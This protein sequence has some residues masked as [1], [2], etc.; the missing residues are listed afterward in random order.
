MNIAVI[1]TGG[2]QYL[3]K[4]GDILKVEKID[5]S[6]IKAGKVTFDEILLVDDGKET[7]VGTPTVK[8]AK[9]VAEVINQVKDKK[10]TVIRF[11]SKSRYFKKRGH[12]QPVAFIK[13]SEIK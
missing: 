6:D 5:E 3:V 8:G 4:E 13:I 7:K 11:K 12:R 10:V 9:V 1:K 2:K